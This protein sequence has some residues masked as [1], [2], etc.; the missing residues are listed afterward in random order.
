MGAWAEILAGLLGRRPPHLQVGALCLRTRSGRTEVLL[1]TSLGSGR[2]IIPKGWPMR[3]RTLSG[4]ALQEA[5][6]EAGVK[7]QVAKAPIGRFSYLK[8]QD[9]GLALNCEVHVFEVRTAS[10]SERF[11]EAGR[12]ERHWMP[13]RQA[14]DLVHEQGLKSLLL[15]AADDSTV[16]SKDR[17][18]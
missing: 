18:G 2:W 3:G 6:E 10:V 12:R 13:L 5:W 17:N 1:I 8:A 15:A 14:V 7:G 16:V 11:P 4:A 9:N